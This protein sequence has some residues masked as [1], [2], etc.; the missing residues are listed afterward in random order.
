MLLPQVRH[1]LL[2]KLESFS[3]VR[4]SRRCHRRCFSSTASLLRLRH[5]SKGLALYVVVERVEQR[6]RVFLCDSQQD[7][8][9]ENISFMNTTEIALP[10]TPC[11]YF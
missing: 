7:G 10:Y 11:R 3:V 1:N 6:L 5:N 2:G 9:L 4:Q 8:L